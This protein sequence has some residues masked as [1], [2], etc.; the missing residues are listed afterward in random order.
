MQG[1]REGVLASLIVWVTLKSPDISVYWLSGLAGTGKS[2]INRSFC[3][4]VA[5]LSQY[6]VLSFFASKNDV[7][8]RDP[9]SIL[10]TFVYELA[11]T[12]A[13]F[14]GHLL[15]ALR[16]HP[17]IKH[18]SMREQVETLLA[19]PLE[20]TI[21][22]STI[23]PTLVFTIDALD[24]CHDTLQSE[25]A[26][27][28]RET[29]RSLA[30]LPCKLLVTSRPEEPI[31]EMFNSL[32]NKDTQFLHDL[33][34]DEVAADVRLVWEAGFKNIVTTLRVKPL[35]WPTDEAKRHLIERTGYLFIFASTVLRYVGDPEVREPQIRLQQVLEKRAVMKSDNPYAD[36]DQI[37][38]QILN[39]S[40][41]DSTKRVSPTICE[42]LRLIVGAVCFLQYPLSESDLAAL[43]KLS[44]SAVERDVSKLSAVLVRHKDGDISHASTVRLL[45]PSFRDFLLDTGRC[46]DVR[47]SIDS[48][49]QH[50]DLAM[51]CLELLNT[52]LKKDICEIGDFT[53]SNAEVK[54]PPL[55]TRLNMYILGAVQYACCFWHVHL[56]L[57]AMQPSP[58]LVSALKE[59]LSSHILHWIELLGLMGRVEHAIRTL[60]SAITWCQVRHS[61]YLRDK[62]EILAELWKLK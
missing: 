20:A 43:L 30:G 8:R 9:F 61:L 55:S 54:N 12:H 51:L 40:T 3:E 32:P 21:S 26:A 59:F 23:F 1:T 45:H 36:I 25:A 48:A 2:T 57:S 62:A 13:G 50:Q 35:P 39:S 31:L 24:E 60:P 37:Y 11:I 33:N 56:S 16:R 6:Y 52:A 42:R 58:G 14:R 47:F 38:L 28:I 34:Q 44:E 49:H 7:K 53:L 46:E 29:T 15:D 17:K 10:Y 5:R 27:L 18:G 4:Q 22:R 41:Y 19:R